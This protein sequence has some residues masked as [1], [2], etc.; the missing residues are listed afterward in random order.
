MNLK[1]LLCIAMGVFVAHLAGFM[2]VFSIRSRNLPPVTPPP[3][4][5]FRMAEE[6]VKDPK[7]GTKIVNREITVSTELRPEYYRGK[8]ASPPQKNASK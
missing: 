8:D 6:I 4:P 5:T 1:L 3:T 7:T 2:V